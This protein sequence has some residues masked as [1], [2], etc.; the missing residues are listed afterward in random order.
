MAKNKNKG[1]EAPKTQDK[2]E[3]VVVDNKKK[4]DTTVTV[5]TAP[6][7][8]SKKDNQQQKKQT[9]APKPNPESSGKVENVAAEEVQSFQDKLLHP[10][11]AKSL[12]EMKFDSFSTMDANHQAILLHAATEFYKTRDPHA[13]STMFAKDMLD[14]NF[15]YALV[16]VSVQNWQEGKGNGLNVPTALVEQYVGAFNAFGMAL[17]PTRVSADGTQT[18]LKFD[19]T[20]SDAEAI[21]EVKKDN[22]TAQKIERKE[23]VIE[24]DPEKWE[25]NDD[26]A[27]GLAAQIS[28][29]GPAGENFHTMIEKA[30]TYLLKMA[31][32][33]KTE[34]YGNY[35][36]GDWF[37][38]AMTLMGKKSILFSRGMVS[39]VVSSMK[40]DH[41]VVF[42]HCMVRLAMPKLNDEEARDLVKSFVFVKNSETEVPIDQDLAVK[43]GITS[44][45]RDNLLEF[46]T[47]LTSKGHKVMAKLKALYKDE[48]GNPSEDTYVRNSVN[49]MIDITNMYLEKDAALTH[50]EEKEYPA[51]YKTVVDKL[52]EEE[53][54]D[55]KIMDKK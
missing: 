44:V 43:N 22:E 16:R 49:K 3:P 26:A 29:P 47:D 21:E 23:I 40:G 37:K 5:T 52:A 6:G 28:Q 7:A 1:A 53:A 12:D 14:F 9:A 13:P 27:K 32:A 2:K 8:Q 31:D 46:A 20:A 48:L 39:T 25:N 50:Y 24:L 36:I 42:S 51:A 15:Q 17:N 19:G 45:T 34:E 55:K 4:D 41:N 38:A 30:K 11:V 35:T 18:E 33:K 10:F 54:N